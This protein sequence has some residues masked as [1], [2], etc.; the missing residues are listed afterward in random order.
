LHVNENK[1]RDYFFLSNLDENTWN[2]ILEKV[3]KG[4]WLEAF[5]LEKKIENTGFRNAINTYITL[6]K[7]ESMDNFSPQEAKGL[8]EFNTENSFLFSFD[9]FNKIIENLYLSDVLKYEN[10]EKYFG[11][12]PSKNIDLNIKLFK[13]Q[14]EYLKNTEK[15]ES[16]LNKKMKELN[17]KLNNFWIYKDLNGKEELTFHQNFSDSIHDS[18]TIFKM[19]LLVF[20]KKDFSRGLNYLK[21]EDYQKFFKIILNINTATGNLDKLLKDIPKQLA[22]D[23]TLLFAKVLYFRRIKEHDKVVEILL[24]LKEEEIFATY[25]WLYRHIYARNLLGEKKYKQAYTI[26]SSFAGK[27]G[28]DYVESQW[29][30]GWIAFN[31]LKQNA[32]ALKHFQNFY[33][34]VAF[35]TS[36]AD[37]AYW[38]AKIY[39]SNNM[40]KDALKWF[41]TSAKYSTTFY[42]QLSHYAKHNILATDGE[43]YQ[44]IIFPKPQEATEEEKNSLNNNRIVK[45]GILYLRYLNERDN[46]F[47]ILKYSIQKH[48]K[49]RG[50][51][52]ELIEILETFNDETIII[53]L[54]K[55]ASHRL[56][57]F[58]EHLFPKL[59]SMKKDGEEVSLVHA[60]IKQESGFVIKAESPVGALGFM[61]IMP[62]TAKQLS[63]ELKITYS[64]Y[65]LRHDPQY[66]MV[67]G[68]YYIKSLLKQYHDSKVLAIAAYNAGP[69]SCNRWINDYGDPRENDSVEGVVN[70]IESIPYK[71]TRNY[72]KRVLENLIV[73]E[74]VLQ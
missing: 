8:I 17:R 4:S 13:D 60:I 27:K 71:E 25:W 37:G 19:K 74:Y 9:D 68:K 45:L 28:S 26:S 66:N 2:E 24:N 23:E 47:D 12:F 5:K 41:D 30:S 35:P 70:W 67:L 65:K 43:P 48:L 72:V 59:R 39:E 22:K 51:I 44:E 18:S 42:G 69:N 64:Q 38:I 6:K 31:Y 21:N 40:K 63:K 14:E 54:A 46:G 55:F 50:E 58:L 15:D 29:L 11:S 33:S 57:F 73:Y 61:Q 49:K 32:V 36:I 10:V 62:A 20:K 53:P 34:Y 1:E 52:A 16:E 7:F 56:V 3:K